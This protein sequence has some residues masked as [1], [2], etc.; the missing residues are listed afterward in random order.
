MT[1]P[2]AN[3]NRDDGYPICAGD[4]R[5]QRTDGARLKPPETQ[6]DAPICPWCDRQGWDTCQHADD[7][8]TCGK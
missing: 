1:Y 4:E 3:C 7:A 2:C 5:C 8:R 6:T